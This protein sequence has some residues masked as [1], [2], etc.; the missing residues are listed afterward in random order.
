[1]NYE[2]KAKEKLF[3]IKLEADYVVKYLPF[4]H[5]NLKEI[6]TT[7]RRTKAVKVINFRMLELECETGNWRFRT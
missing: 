3:N 6:G 7:G 2:I 1:M 5:A 4:Y